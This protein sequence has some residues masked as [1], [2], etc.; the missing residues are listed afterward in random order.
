MTGLRAQITVD[1][2]K[3]APGRP[4]A[5]D[6]YDRIRDQAAD[7]IQRLGP[8]PA[9]QIP[10]ITHSYLKDEAKP[11]R[12]KPVQECIASLADEEASVRRAA[13]WALF[14]M[15]PK[16]APAVPALADLLGD[17]EVR[18]PA[19]RALEAIGPASLPALP[20]LTALTKHPDGFV[21]SGAVFALSAIGAPPSMR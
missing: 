16:A 4:L 7:Y 14:E 2:H 5:L 8:V 13:A 15:G 9:D 20:K 19:I 3:T 11:F 18:M 17:A 21:R 1:P 12:G 6:E 10:P